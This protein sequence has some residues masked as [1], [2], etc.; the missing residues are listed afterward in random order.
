MGRGRDVVSEQS[1]AVV[2]L[3]VGGAL[4]EGFDREGVASLEQLADVRQ[5][6]L[7][8]RLSERASEYRMSE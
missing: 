4:G 3:G 8:P 6:F 2:L 5:R 1:P 7:H